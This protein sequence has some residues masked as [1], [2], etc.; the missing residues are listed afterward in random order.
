MRQ[1]FWRSFDR[2]G[3]VHRATSGSTDSSQSKKLDQSL[4]E[5]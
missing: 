2:T 5:R 3:G 4:A 1:M